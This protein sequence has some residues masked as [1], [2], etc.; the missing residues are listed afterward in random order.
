MNGGIAA[1]RVT[2][3]V[4]LRWSNANGEWRQLG[5]NDWNAVRAS[6]QMPR[7]LRRQETRCLRGARDQDNEGNE[8]TGKYE[9]MTR[10]NGY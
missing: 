2:T 3:A 7:V 9:Q 10:V 1:K 8:P 6:L 5:G 4:P